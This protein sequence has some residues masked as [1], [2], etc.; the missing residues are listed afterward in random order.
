MEET[1]RTGLATSRRSKSFD[2]GVLWWP[3]WP[4]VVPDDRR[5]TLEVGGREG[6]EWGSWIGIGET[7][8][9]AHQGK[10]GEQ[11][12]QPNPDGWR[13][14]GARETY[15]VVGQWRW[16]TA[17]VAQTWT[18]GEGAK[19]GRDDG[20]RLFWK[21]GLVARTERG[22]RG[23]VW[24]HPRGGRRRREEGG[25]HCDR[26]RGAAGSGPRPSGAG[27]V[28]VAEH[29]R[30]AGH[31]WRGAAQLTSRA[32]WVGGPVSA[33]GCGRERGEWGSGGADLLARPAQCQAAR[34]KLSLKLVQSYSNGSKGIRIPSNFRWFKRYLPMPPKSLNKIWLER[35]WDAKQLCL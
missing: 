5:R 30:A 35:V 26:Q 24:A 2:S 17:P 6:G 22:K 14:P 23:P 21:I 11:R 7:R 10:G 16:R 27:G 29:G 32:G 9:A 12:R 8:K 28:V 13:R 4:P 34:F 25:W 31:M 33:T 20:R 18:R 1:H 3:R 19:G 15:G